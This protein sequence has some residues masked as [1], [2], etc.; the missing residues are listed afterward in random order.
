MN[1]MENN[2]TLFLQAAGVHQGLQYKAKIMGK[3]MIRGDFDRN[4]NSTA[5]VG[6]NIPFT[7]T[8]LSM[9]LFTVYVTSIRI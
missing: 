1:G 5:Y 9:Q 6:W 7:R 3:G 2:V 8:L 4:N